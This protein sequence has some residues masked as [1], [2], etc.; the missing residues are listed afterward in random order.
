MLLKLLAENDGHI[1]EYDLEGADDWK[2]AAFFTSKADAVKWAGEQADE[3]TR[4]RVRPS[5]R[6]QIVAA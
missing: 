5:V 2:L 4:Y 3:P 6:R 1:V